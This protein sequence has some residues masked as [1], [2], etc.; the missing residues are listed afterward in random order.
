MGTTVLPI[1]QGLLWDLNELAFTVKCLEYSK[2]NIMINKRGSNSWFYVYNWL[3]K[4]NQVVKLQRVH[5]QRIAVNNNVARVQTR[6][7]HESLPNGGMGKEF[8]MRNQKIWVW[9]P[10]LS[11]PSYVILGSL[12]FLFY[13]LFF[14]Q[15]NGANDLLITQGCKPVNVS[16][17][18]L[19]TT[20]LEQMQMISYYFYKLY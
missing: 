17:N 8:R 15:Q 5:L 20:K 1:S 11:F 9:V 2:H 3:G 10:G 19:L 6:K 4:A 7:S 12:R 13:F 14:H 16:K 18:A